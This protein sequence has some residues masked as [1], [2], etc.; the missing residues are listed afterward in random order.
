MLRK[1]IRLA[2]LSVLAAG[3]AGAGELVAPESTG[4]WQA[5]LAEQSPY[6][7]LMD[8]GVPL[9]PTRADVAK[10]PAVE[11]V[12]RQTALKQVLL[13]RN[14]RSYA[15]HKRV[16]DA[17]LLASARLA[18]ELGAPPQLAVYLRLLAA[19]TLSSRQR[20]W[21]R[22][23]LDCLIE[24]YLVDA[25]RMRYFVEFSA[26]S[27]AQLEDLLSWLPLQAT[28]NLVPV[29]Q[30]EATVVADYQLLRGVYAQLLAAYQSAQ[31]KESADAAA[32]TALQPFIL[33]ETT[34][35]T[36]PFAPQELKDRLA[37]LYG[38]LLTAPALA[39]QQERKRLRENDYFGSLRLRL[40]D[41]LLG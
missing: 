26:L 30:D 24:A 25:L 20:Y 35:Y 7:E 33:H 27:E 5:A 37:P 17:N 19:D 12:H 14:V 2:W 28:F 8:A 6:A 18:D 22:E 4:A 10:L 16:S 23:A 38:R 11:F 29:T 9:P 39:L 13:T 1:W 36:R 32:E 15:E 40:L 31:D 3:S 34:T 41:L 21:V